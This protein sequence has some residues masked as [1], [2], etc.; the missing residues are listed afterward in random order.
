M[1]WLFIILLL[2][3]SVSPYVLISTSN[4]TVLPSGHFIFFPLDVKSPQILTYSWNA[5]GDIEVSLMT[6]S[7]FN[8]FVNG[9]TTAF[10]GL[11]ITNSSYR[12][13]LLLMP[14]SY[15]LVFYA[16]M[17]QVTLNYSYNLSNT[18]V[19]YSLQPGYYEYYTLNL[20]YPFHLN[21]FLV[22]N[23]SISV[24]VYSKNTTFL[25]LSPPSR[26]ILTFV[27]KTITLNPGEYN[28]TIRGVGNTTTSIYD[29]ITYSSIYPN[30]LSLNKV[31]YPMGVASYGVFNESGVLVPYS[32]IASSVIGLVN[33]TSIMEYNATEKLL[34]VSPYSASLQLNVPVVVVNGIHNQTYW[35]QNV[36]TFL[37]NESALC[38]DSSILNVSN[39]NATLSNFSIQGKGAVYPPFNSGYYYRYATHTVKYKEPLAFLLSINVSVLKKL[40]VNLKFGVKLLQNG[41][42]KGG[43]WTYFDSVL[44]NDPSVTKAYLYVSGYSSPEVLNYYD[45]ELVFGGGGNGGTAQFLNLS[46]YLALFYYNGSTR[47]FPSVYSMGGDTAETASNVQVYLKSGA[48]YVTVGQDDPKFLTN[49]FSATLP[50]ASKNQVSNVSLNT[51]NTSTTNTSSSGS[52]VQNNSTITTSNSTSSKTGTPPNSS[53][54]TTPTTQSKGYKGFNFPITYVVIGI[55]VVIV[56]VLMLMRRSRRPDLNIEP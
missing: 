21:L 11:Y 17:G 34:N 24:E 56:I 8:A 28:V 2:V 5:S 43:N 44:I 53:N 6:S 55:V 10:T 4:S 22:S 40:G 47:A 32:V 46:A 19:T 50:Q 35:A 48:V 36:V 45:A 7:Q 18:N 25:S 31:Y 20:T 14:G 23:S 54:S 30:P 3:A 39:E 38:Y 37:T 1:K 41:T 33:I 51:T 26:S 15:Y 12:N 27:N 49:Q 52:K 13:E 9:T 16:F 42:Y 29:L